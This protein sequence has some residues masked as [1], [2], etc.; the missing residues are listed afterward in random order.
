MLSVGK[1]QER[2]TGRMSIY[3]K[4][5]PTSMREGYVE[6][7]GA[8]VAFMGVSQEMLGQ[9]SGSKHP[10]GVLAFALQSGKVQR[11]KYDSKS[12]HIAGELRM[13]MDASWLSAFATPV[14]DGRND[15]FATPTVPVSASLNIDL[16]KPLPDRGEELS[17]VPGTLNIHLRSEKAT[18]EKIDIPEIAVR[19]IK[20][21][22]FDWQLAPIYI[23]EVAQRLCVQPVQL[24][25][26]RWFGWPFIQLSG[27]GLAFGEPGARTEWGKDDV[28][29]EMREWK[30]ISAGNFWELSES[31]ASDLRAEVDD[32]DCVEVFFVNS[33]DPDDQWGGGATWGS[34]TASSKVISSDDNA[35]G[36]IDLT[37]LG[38][39]LGHVLGL[40]HPGG[41]SSSST[42]PAS[43]G[44]LMCPSGFHNDNPRVN[45]QDNEDAVS[46][47]LLYF[48]LKI[49]SPGPDCTDSADCGA[50]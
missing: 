23:F 39:E 18:Y 35:R 37:H 21:T 1:S 25:R 7:V 26:F 20:P 36:G 48:S 49:W 10:L 2:V 5:T 33:L 45:S 44:T 46:N 3:L 41:G 8:N 42:V 28:T 17:T 43:T 22:I 27:A 6:A 38:H 50:C 16:G 32:D 13:Y 14:S 30:T 4:G 9:K 15:F 31:E 19:F 47:P 12:G 34:G 40:G 24:L 11:L 29:L